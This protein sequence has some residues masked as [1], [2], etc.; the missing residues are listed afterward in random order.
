MTD[1]DALVKI[2][3]IYLECMYIDDTTHTLGQIIDTV[4]HCSK[5]FFKDEDTS[6][7]RLAMEHNASARVSAYKRLE[8]VSDAAQA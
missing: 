6:Y 1:E 5:I 3:L 4:H 8:K 7:D 2:T